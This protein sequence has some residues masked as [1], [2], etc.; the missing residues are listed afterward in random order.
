M[1]DQLATI[2][3]QDGNAALVEEYLSQRFLERRDYDTVLAN[4]QFAQEFQL[5]KN[6]GGSLK[7]LRKGRFRMPQ[8]VPMS[9]PAVDPA[10]GAEYSAETLKVPQEYIHE[11]VPIQTI[12]EWESWVDLENW[13]DEDMPEALMRRN[14]QLT[15]NALKV[16]RF[17]PGV[18][19]ADGTA[20]VAF[21]TTVEATVT[22][23]GNSFTFDSAPAYFANA[24]NSFNALDEND[25]ITFGD[26]EA[27]K[28]AL[29]LAGARTIDGAY[30]CVLSES[31]ASD[32]QEDDKYFK[33]AVEAWKGEG[34][35]QGTLVKYKRWWFMIDDE[36][37]TEDWGAPLVRATNGPIHTAFCFGKSAFAYQRLGSM[38]KG[39]PKFKVQDLSKTGVEKTIGYLVPFQAAVSNPAWC[40][41]LTAPV[42]H[43]TPNNG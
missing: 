8:K 7:V 29:S 41:T 14:H 24:K 5:P 10:S 11:Y 21:D 15:Q 16:G 13:A 35:R 30:V 1:D 37:F 28:V 23:Q 43:Y 42:S 19:A 2:L 33:T 27:R 17:K 20:S 6:A 32:L 26:L 40:C 18:W 25:R 31:M 39:K 3:D 9:T 36:P 22:K 4:S 34:I 38:G 12:A